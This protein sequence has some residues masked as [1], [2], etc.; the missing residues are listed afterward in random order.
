VNALTQAISPMRL[1]MADLHRI[2]DIYIFDTGSASDI[3]TAFCFVGQ[4]AA[5]PIAGQGVESFVDGLLQHVRAHHPA[6]VD[7]QVAYRDDYLFRGHR[8]NSKTGPLLALRRIPSRTPDLRE[9]RLPPFWADLLLHPELLKGGLVLM[10]AVTGQGKSTTTASIIGS[11]LKLFGGFGLT[12]EDPAELP[13]HGDHGEGVCIQTEVSSTDA[14]EV[15]YAEA[16]RAA[17]RSYPT[18]TGG[19][20]ILLVGEVRD[21]VTAAELVRAAVN[22]HLVVTTI[23]A[24]DLNTAIS[25]LSALAAQ[26]LGDVPARDLLASALKVAVHQTL[27]ISNEGDGW[28]R[29]VVGGELIWS[30]H[31]ASP[32]ASAIRTGQFISINQVVADQTA[33]MR[34]TPKPS[35]VELM[36]NLNGMG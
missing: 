9:L 26:K 12:I 10:A 31:N 21:P 35:M 5:V 30:G 18:L 25:R 1:E 4:A 2:R 20:T 15:A 6:D 24:S 29:G 33:F 8:I 36:R 3:E 27:S 22:G 16:L 23:H 17:M 7:F 32:L 28:S 34:R 14:P 13:L 19:G 11:R